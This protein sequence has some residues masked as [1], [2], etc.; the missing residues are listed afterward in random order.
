MT[1]K[2]L[3]PLTPDFNP[4]N[5]KWCDTHGRMECTAKRS[6]GR[7]ECHGPAVRG[8]DKCKMHVGI[9]PAIAHQQGE[10]MITAWQ[11]HGA[12][13]IVDHKMA[14]LAVLQMSWLRLSAYS[15]LLRRQATTVEGEIVGTADLDNPEDV[16]GSGIV[17]YRFGAAGKDGN[18]YA[19]GEEV[20]ALVALEAQERDRVVRYAKTAHD[21]GISDRL[22]DLAERWGDIVAGRIT[23]ILAELQLTAEQ[24][25]R[26]PEL[27][28]THLSALEMSEGGL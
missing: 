11:A 26:V 1:R 20:R 28:T 25:R 27:L 16:R 12:G 17:G 3:T 13:K 21:M 22:T 9:R 15:E 18:I 24:E 10:A 8:K 19:Q 14:V 5:A 2:P 7:G 23:I 6:R 4:G